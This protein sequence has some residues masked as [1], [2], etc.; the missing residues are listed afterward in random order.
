MVYHGHDAFDGPRQ[1]GAAA[2]TEEVL[3]EGYESESRDIEYL[4]EH[5][6]GSSDDSSV[7]R[8]LEEE[9]DEKKENGPNISDK[10]DE[11]IG[12]TEDE[13]Q[14]IIKSVAEPVSGPVEPAE[15]KDEK[16][17]GD[18]RKKAIA[19]SVEDLI[20]SLQKDKKEVIDLDKRSSKIEVIR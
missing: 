6:Y 3:N 14:A 19:K 15:H 20:E 12:E 16:P 18:S 7:Y 13:D 2:G 5:K 4:N 17:P 9:E 11:I 8:S 1:Y 10:V